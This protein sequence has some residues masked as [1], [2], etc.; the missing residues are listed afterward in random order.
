MEVSKFH[1]QHLINKK[2][3]RMQLQYKY[4]YSFIYKLCTCSMLMY[5][6]NF[7]Q[8]EHFQG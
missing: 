7:A 8:E 4:I 1:D 2:L 3:L 5:Y 6:G